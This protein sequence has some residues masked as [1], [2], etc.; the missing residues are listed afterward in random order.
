MSLI[1]HLESSEGARLVIDETFRVV[2]GTWLGG[3]TGV[4]VLLVNP[5]TDCQLEVVVL[6][7]GF[8]VL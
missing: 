6:V 7:L 5:A 1:C 8:I 2:L 3:R 4:T